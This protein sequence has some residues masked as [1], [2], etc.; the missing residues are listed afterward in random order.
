MKDFKLL[1]GFESIGLVETIIDVFERNN[2]SLSVERLE[3]INDIA[4]MVNGNME[5]SLIIQRVGNQIVLDSWR[6]ELDSLYPMIQKHNIVPE[7]QT[8]R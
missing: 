5:E 6:Q 2:I 4:S 8:L 1:S 3:R 7:I